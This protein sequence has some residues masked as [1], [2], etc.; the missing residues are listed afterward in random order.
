MA[1]TGAITTFTSHNI[2]FNIYYKVLTSLQ[3]AGWNIQKN[4]NIIYMV[5][6]TFEW[7]LAPF[8]NF[9]S[10]I[11]LIN[12]SINNKKETCIELTWNNF[13]S[14]GL[15]YFSDSSITITITDNPQYLKH[16]Q[17]IDF[18]WYLEK[19]YTLF[20]HLDFYRIECVY[21]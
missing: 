8:D 1:K 13:N 17:I 3:E 7:D 4:A 21:D 20:K 15:N 11:K 6:G 2:D 18:S 9:D 12:K 14:I 10:I 16:S 19:I 5:D